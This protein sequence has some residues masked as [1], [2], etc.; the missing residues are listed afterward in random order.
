ME[1]LP[2]NF[3]SVPPT[4]ELC[5]NKD[6]PRKDTCMRYFAGQHLPDDKTVGH[7]IY[8]NALQ[9]G[10]CKFY[11]EKRV[12][13]AAWGFHNLF[14]NVKRI[15]RHSDT[16]RNSAI[17]RESPHLLPLHERTTHPHARATRGYYKHLPLVW[18]HR[19]VKLR[20]LLYPLCL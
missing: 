2:F 8:P 9:K 20:Q 11:V 17:S 5:F 10:K 15:G 7:A 6:C 19:R 12:I 18:L 3:A 13:R 16:Q 14:L 1:Q 4:W